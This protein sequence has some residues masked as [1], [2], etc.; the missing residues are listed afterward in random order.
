MKKVII[1]GSSGFIGKSLVKY[2]KRRYEVIELDLV[3][4]QDLTDEKFVKA[5]FKKNRANYLV[6]LFGLND[7]VGSGRQK[8]NIFTVPLESFERYMKVNLTAMFSVCR[9]FARNNRK[10]DRAIVNFSST[11]GVVSP[12]PNMYNGKEK[13]IGYSVSKAGII[14]LT[15]HLAAHLA[16]GMRV[17][18]VVPGGIKGKQSAK[19][20]KEYSS[21]TPIGR[22]M[23]VS[24][25]NGIVSYLCSDESSYATGAIFCIDGGWTIW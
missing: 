10:D 12:F 24:E 11:Y 8:Q 25:I 13:H 15:K 2:M 6:N 16:P 18:C 14:M 19:F 4:G 23:K 20:K 5:W 21:R 3:K 22:M 9:E 7:H 1:A 17:N